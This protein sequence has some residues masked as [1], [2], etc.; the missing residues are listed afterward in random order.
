MAINAN[1]K[2]IG[3]LVADD[4]R[5]TGK[6]S[7][8]RAKEALAR[9]IR[10]RLSELD[11]SPADLARKSGLSRDNISTYM[12]ASSLPS[13]ELLGMLAHGLDT[14][15]EDLMPTRVDL[16]YSDPDK[17]TLEITAVPS[18]P[19]KAWLRVDQLVNVATAT[20][21]MELLQKEASND[22]A[23]DGKRGR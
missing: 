9:K 12:R 22:D 3:G 21:I 13:Q 10:Q 5:T 8:Q 11:M 20:K 1:A 18:Q 23:A 16:T 17:P 15:I 7:R 19:G 2:K 6:R 14:K 4:I